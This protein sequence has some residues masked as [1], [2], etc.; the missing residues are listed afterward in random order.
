MA[1]PIALQLYTLR[2]ILP[3]DYTAGIRAIA[4]MGY[5]VVET[6]EMYGTTPQ[7]ASRLFKDLNLSVTSMHDFPIPDRQS[8]ARIVDI[9]GV[10]GCQRV[11]SGGDESD[12]Q[13]RETIKRISEL[14]NEAATLLA[15]HGLSI[16]IHNHWGEVNLVEGR[17]AYEIMLDYLLPEVFFQVDTYWAQV[18]G[19]D[20]VE[21]IRRLGKRAP[22]LHIKDGPVS[23]RLKQTPVGDGKLDFPAI[24]KASEG[25][26]EWLI[27]EMDSCTIDIMKAVEKSYH[28]LVKNGLAS[29]KK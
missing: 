10:L 1:A 6:D 19:V 26:A 9:A 18:G 11:V 17:P 15:L 20:P 23:K 7:E 21:M 25:T 8:L 4:A 5:L 13:D 22:L 2:K 28:Y 29:G 12:F 27:V 14:F 24:V 3:K 16:G